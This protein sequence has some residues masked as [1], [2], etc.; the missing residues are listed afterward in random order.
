[1]ANERK[2]DELALYHDWKGTQSTKSFQKLYT[3]MKPLIYDAARKASYGSNIPESA[4]QIWAAQNFYDALRTY[5]PSAGTALQTH[6][7]N[8]VHQ[9]AKR[10]NYLYQNLGHIPEPRAMQ[11][12]LYQNIH[13]NLRATLGREPSSAE[14]ADKLSWGLK[15]VVNIQKEL[16]KEMAMDLGAEEHGVFESSID[17]EVLEY[18]Y[19]ELNGEEQLM[20]DYVFGKHGKPRMV[21]ANKKVD[22]EGIARKAGFSA[23]KARGI[24]TKVRL[25]VEKALHR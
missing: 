21:K 18:V 4:H 9:K 19:Y 20:Y 24:W 11:I 5:K 6:V 15:D 14:I 22:F 17:E 2:T 1:V 13:E 25:K 3:S 7:Y 12:G 23:S 8:A 10:L 16:Q